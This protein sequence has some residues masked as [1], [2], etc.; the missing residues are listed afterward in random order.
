VAA[1]SA[2]IEE[3]TAS[4]D[5]TAKR[6]EAVAETVSETSATIEEMMSSIEAVARNAGV[7]SLAASRVSQTVSDMAGAVS[8][9]G[10]I[11]EEADTI[12][13]RASADARMGDEAVAKTLEGMKSVSDAM[14]NVAR[15]IK[16]LGTRSQEI[17]RIVELIEDIADQTNLLALNA[18]IEAARAGE[19]G[20]GFA[21]VAD[22]VRKLAERSVAATKEIV[23]LIDHVQQETTGRDGQG[24]RRGDEGRDR[25]RRPGGPRPE[26]DP[27][28]RLPVEPAHGRDRLLHEQAIARLGRA[29]AHRRRHELVG[30][31]GHDGRQGAG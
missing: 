18:A 3:M 10:K 31:P 25:P 17:G 23:E 12:S 22:E 11:T 13:R 14:E 6:L 9:V 5:Q 4:T 7:L 28:V 1:A 16:G 30:G 27:G 20:R 26:R 21:V 2:T 29:D 19:A 8:D 15:V 24:R